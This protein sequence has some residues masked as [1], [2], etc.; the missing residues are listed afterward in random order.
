MLSAEERRKISVLAEKVRGAIDPNF[1]NISIEEFLE[2]SGIEIKYFDDQRFDAFVQWD[3]EKCKPIIAVNVCT[4]KVRQRFSIAHE[5]GHLVLDWHWVPNYDNTDVIEE[6]NERK[7]LSVQ[8][9]GKDNYSKEEYKREEY[10]NE[11]AASFLMPNNYLDRMLQDNAKDMDGESIAEI[12]SLD[13]GVSLVAAN[14]RMD[15]YISYN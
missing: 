8:Y 14:I 11:F 9:R 3:K 12:I 15:N 1:N 2:K 5:L 4:S 13:C 6:L 10:A 7:F